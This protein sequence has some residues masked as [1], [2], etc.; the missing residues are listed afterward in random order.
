MSKILKRIIS[1]VMAAV[2]L[3]CSGAVASVS[4]FEGDVLESGYCGNDLEYTVWVSGELEIYGEGDMWDFDHDYDD[5]PWNDYYEHITSIYVSEGVTSIGDHAFWW[6]DETN[7]L[8][9]PSTL[10]YIG[11]CSIDFDPDEY[12]MVI[13]N[14]TEDEWCDIAYSDGEYGSECCDTF[15]FAAFDLYLNGEEPWFYFEGRDPVPVKYGDILV[16]SVYSETVIPEGASLYWEAEGY[17]VEMEYSESDECFY[18]RANDTGSVDIYIGI[19]YEDGR[20]DYCDYISVETRSNFFLMI[21]SLFKDLFR[22]NR[23]VY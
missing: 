2:M 19:Q 10:E 3:L 5:I 20:V 12:Y 22:I 13:F 4:A 11:V 7:K 6:L 9:L 14:G 18:I 21:I 17:G 23:Y 8:Y 15:D 16:L 1:L